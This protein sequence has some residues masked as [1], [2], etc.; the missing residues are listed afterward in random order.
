MFEDAQ[1]DKQKALFKLLKSM[2][3]IDK[4]L[5]TYGYMNLPKFNFQYSNSRCG[6]LV[7]NG[8]YFS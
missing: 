2:G 4:I 1:Y 7:E 3:F 6:V 8:C 5:P